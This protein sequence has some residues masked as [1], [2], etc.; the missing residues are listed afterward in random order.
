MLHIIATPKGR[1]THFLVSQV[2]QMLPELKEHLMQEDQQDF[3]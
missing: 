1:S 2:L 3:W